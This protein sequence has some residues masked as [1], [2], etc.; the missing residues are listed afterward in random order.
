MQN[1]EWSLIGFTLIS[2]LS[3]GFIFLANIS[4]FLNNSMSSAIWWKSPELLIL[5]LL[6]I[7]GLI[8]LLHLGNPVNA[9]KSINNLSSSWI[10][11]EI[12]ALGVL[13]FFL[14]ILML[15]KYLFTA[16]QWIIS[17]LYII[18]SFIGI[19]FIYS[20][21]RI[22]MIETVPSWNCI[23]TPISFFSSVLLFLILGCFYLSIK[24]DIVPI[25]AVKLLLIIFLIV[26][27]AMGILNQIYLNG[28]EIKGIEN[29]SF[30]EGMFYSLFL[31]R[32]ILLILSI[33]ALVLL[34]IEPA[35]IPGKNIF[36]FLII[37]ILLTQELITRLLFYQSYF[38]LG[39]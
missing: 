24:S 26:H 20:M 2:Q 39:M 5:I 17:I 4:Y 12:L 21:T 16:P 7:A 36:I 31:L 28:L 6:G 23:Y 8:S 35:F 3:V 30:K 9:P 14:L 13:V 18:S 15:A 1:N 19:L 27:L 22:Y 25:N 10:S 11:R 34:Y 33:L 29:I 32:I 37:S 38:R